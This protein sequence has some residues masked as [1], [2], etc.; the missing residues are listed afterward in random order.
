M[1]SIFDDEER[2]RKLNARKAALPS[3]LQMQSQGIENLGDIF[4]L[5]SEA[6]TSFAERQRRAMTGYKPKYPERLLETEKP[7][8]WWKEKA[9]LNSMNT[10]IPM[11]GFAVGSVM[12]AIPNPIAKLVGKAIN[13][14]TAATTYNANFADTLQEHEDLAGRELTR[15]EK[16]KA[17]Q[18][19]A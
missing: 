12:Q 11:L 9:T 13:F 15:A 18:R 17:A 16:I 4:N 14:T 1:A 8:E 5:E 7:F 6:V 10:V 3:Y 2:V 19:G